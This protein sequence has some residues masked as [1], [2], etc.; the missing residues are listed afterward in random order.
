MI[1][2]DAMGL[3]TLGP[4]PEPNYHSIVNNSS[5]KSAR[6]KFDVVGHQKFGNSTD[7][8]AEVGH[9]TDRDRGHYKHLRNNKNVEV[10]S[11]R[12][13]DQCNKK[14][15][16]QPKLNNMKQSH[17]RLLQT[18]EF[19]TSPTHANVDLC[20]SATGSQISDFES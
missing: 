14:R 11:Y 4:I 12:R 17:L 6:Q 9:S 20:S 19:K 5:T 3:R 8:G 16:R 2:P 18:G 1:K 13:G 15:K 7:F 10:V